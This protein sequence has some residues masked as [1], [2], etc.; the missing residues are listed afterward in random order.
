LNNRTELRRSEEQFRRIAAPLNCLH[1]THSGV[2][3]RYKGLCKRKSGGVQ[4]GR[5]PP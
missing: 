3:R 4:R 2:H 1:M 5:S